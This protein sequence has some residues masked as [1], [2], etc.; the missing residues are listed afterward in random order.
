[1]LSLDGL[2][3]LIKT[4]H[5]YKVYKLIVEYLSNLLKFLYKN[6]IN[7]SRMGKSLQIRIIVDNLFMCNNTHTHTHL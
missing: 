7:K 3:T 4:L 2:Q 5:Q 6:V 1:M